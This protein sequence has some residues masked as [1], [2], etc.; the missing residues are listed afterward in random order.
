MKIHN[1]Y[2][3]E[4]NITRIIRAVLAGSL[5]ISYYYSKEFLFLFIGIMLGVQVVFNISCP[6]RSCE[7]TYKNDTKTKIEFEKYKPKK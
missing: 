3:K 6:G 2:F 5:L 4:W 1:N 7:P